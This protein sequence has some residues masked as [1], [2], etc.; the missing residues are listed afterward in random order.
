MNVQVRLFAIAV[1]QVLF[2]CAP[3]SWS[4]SGDADAGGDADATDVRP[5]IDVLLVLFT[6]HNEAQQYIPS[7][8]YFFPDDFVVPLS[9]AGVDVRVGILSADMGTSGCIID[10]DGCLGCGPCPCDRPDGTSS[11]DGGR[12]VAW[13]PCWP[14]DPGAS[15]WADSDPPGCGPFTLEPPTEGWPGWMEGSDPRFR[16]WLA[17]FAIRGDGCEAAQPLESL[18]QALEPGRNPGFLRDGSILAV[19]IVAPVDDCSTGDPRVFESGMPVDP[20]GAHEKCAYRAEMLYPIERYVDR[21][22][23][24]RPRERLAIAVYAGPDEEYTW[25]TPGTGCSW[26]SE[27]RPCLQW[28]VCVDGLEDVYPSPRLHGFVRLLGH[29]AW[30]SPVGISGQSCPDFFGLHGAAEEDLEAF[31]E[32]VLD[33]VR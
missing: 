27:T 33:R 2:S 13:P 1:V 24:V 7:I 5:A 4:R 14:E 29:T 8:V 28:T 17:C 25:C 32:A 6:D 11:S 31:R 3:G 20:V 26:C 30:G 15:S 19:L 22:L 12:L 16:D 18:Y 9:E 21:L 10:R 23:E